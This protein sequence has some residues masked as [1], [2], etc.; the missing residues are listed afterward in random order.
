LAAFTS[1]RGLAQESDSSS[2]ASAASQESLPAIESSLPEEAPKSIFS[3]TLGKGDEA[4][5]E[6]YVSGTW[7]AEL[8]GSLVFQK[9]E[10]SDGLSLS[11]A[12]PIL[13]TQ[14]PDVFLSFL[15]F[16]KIFVE[17]KVSKDV[18]QTRFAAGYRGD[19]DDLLKEARIGNEGINFPSLPFLSFGEGSYRSFGAAARVESEDFTGRAMVRYDQAERVTKK[20]VGGSEV[21]ETVL[22]PNS[23]VSGK[24]FATYATP[25]T[26]L[27]VYV[28]S[29]SG[30]L[31]GDDG[32]KYRKLGASEYSF[33]ATTGFIAL[34]SAATTRVVAYYPGSGA[35]SD[36]V[37]LSG[38]IDCDLLYEPPPETSTGTVDPKLQVL[39]RYATTSDP[40]SADAYVVDAA[41]GQKDSNYEARIDDDG[42]VEVVWND[43]TIG[44]NRDIYSRPFEAEMDWLYTTDYADPDVLTYA[45]VFTHKVVVRTFSP[46]STITI[47]ED[48]IA[49]SVE[50]KRNG[51]QD[52]AFTVDMENYEVD[53]AT[54]P[55]LAEEIEVS[56]MKESSERRSGVLSA[57]LGGFWKLD[58]GWDAWAALGTSWSVPG[59]SYAADGSTNPGRVSLTG[60]EK[61]SKDKLT[62]QAA[63]AATYSRDDA[64][65]RYR[66]EGMESSSD[67]TSTFRPEATTSFTVV[68]TE[69]EDL[70][71]RF[72]SLIKVLHRDGSSQEALSITAGADPADAFVKIVDTPPYESFK[73]FAFYARIPSDVVLTVSVDDGATTPTPSMQIVLPLGA[74]DGTWHRYIL[75]YG[76]GDATVYSQDDE[77]A[78]EVPVASA[79]STYNVLGTGSRIAISVSGM[80]TGETIWVDEICLE[81]SVGRAAA[82]FQGSIAYSDREFRIGEG[83]LSWLSGIKASADAQGGLSDESYV[84]GGASVKT[85]LGFLGLALNARGSVS[86]EDDPSMRGGHELTLPNVSFPIQVADSFDFD[87]ATGSF[88]REDT[89]SARAGRIANASVAQKTS[90]TPPSY[91]LGEGLLVQEWSGKVSLAESIV[92]IGIDASNRAL[93]S[94]SAFQGES[95]GYFDSWIGSFSYALPA[96]ENYSERRAAKATMSVGGPS[97]SPKIAAFSLGTVAEP[98]TSGGGFRRDTSTMRIDLPLGSRAFAVAPYY[99]RS[100]KDKRDGAGSG[101]VDD[102]VVAI[103]DILGTPVYYA[104]IPFAELISSSR[105]DDFADQTSSASSEVSEAL[106]SSEL[107]LTLSRQFGS[108][109]YDLVVPSALSLAFRRE[110]E[111]DGDQVTD[112]DVWETY[113]K[114][115]SVN[116]FGKLGAYPSRLAFDSDEYSGLLKASIAVPRGGGAAE[117]SIQSQFLATWYAGAADRLD[118][119]N[120]FTLA[121]EPSSGSW[122]EELKLSLST[123]VKRHFLLDLYR[124]AVPARNAAKTDEASAEAT[125]D[126]DS[127]FGE[128]G[129]K[130]SVAS[131]YIEDLSGREPVT[132]SIFSVSG[133]LEGLSSDEDGTS[134]GWSATESYEARLTVPER[135]TL[136]AIASFSQEKDADTQTL[137]IGVELSIGA[138]I[139][140]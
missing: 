12:S 121:S 8:I 65:G 46:A 40:D 77:D 10:S 28:Q 21:G 4:D 95:A 5:A 93:P 104:G 107:G 114:W 54:P 59:T 48:V 11:S 19:E 52:Y 80:T 99:S 71:E 136:K 2:A 115:A 30:T 126:A 68:E 101:I 100:W 135:L 86:Q 125:T 130:V 119:D 50:V 64:T 37:T 57:A 87:P 73:T 27:E 69:E 29:A 58:E 133:G 45:P 97:G 24:Y 134:L 18:S 103:G 89:L 15:L 38:A 22:S 26:G 62:H 49:G 67:Y 53:L 61:Y 47:D 76:S 14:D 51:V 113:G 56:Y 6:L 110:L 109:W 44:D 43:T 42:Y 84:S 123:R 39:C 94:E 36:A 82:L 81:D 75:H 138:M 31:S 78:D 55:S 88:G 127:S 32:N 7:S 79:A 23:Y 124:L 74:G 63:I 137:S 70:A 20:F 108:R 83:K 112:T 106:L 92:S 120:R 72:P 1:P 139:S 13:F 16:K 41:S 33:S 91:L 131:H 35:L 90:W 3:A 17:A 111:R 140:F 85:T 128:D 116:L 132:R 96:F 102:A 117:T 60:G 66:I 118:L 122:S 98:E 105:A 25:A 34:T 9:T 129:K